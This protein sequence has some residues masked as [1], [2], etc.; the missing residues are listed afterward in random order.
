MLSISIAWGRA[1]MMSELIGK[2]VKGYHIHEV[3]RSDEWGTYYRA[4]QAV[5]ERMV[6]IKHI[7]PRY[8]NDPQFIRNFEVEARLVASLEH[9]HILPLYDFWRDREGAYLVSRYVRGSLAQCL[10]Q[11]SLSLKQVGK[12]IEQVGS[13]LHVAH[14]R[15]IIHHRIM[16]TAI[17]LDE[18]GNAYIGDFEIAHY[19]R[20]S[21]TQQISVDTDAGRFDYISP[22]QIHGKAITPQTDMYCLGIVLY[23]MLTG[24]HPFA[25]TSA[26]LKL[27]NHINESLPIIEDLPDEIRD[28][29]NGILRKATEKYPDKRY[30]TVKQLTL[31]LTQ[32]IGEGDD[33]SNPDARQENNIES[34]FWLENP[35]KGLR[36]FQTIDADDFFGRDAFVDKL[37]SRMQEE[38]IYQRFL[39]V[40]GASGSGK[41]SV[42]KAGLLPRLFDGAV[43]DSEGWFTVEMFPSENPLQELETALASVAVQ[44]LDGIIPHL[45]NS[46]RGL[47]HLAQVILPEVSGEL[48][49][50]I[51]QFDEVFTLVGD[52]SKRARFLDLLWFACTHVSSR[53]RVIIALGSD[54]ARLAAKYPRFEKLLNARYE[55]LSKPSEA[56]LRAII[57]GPVTRVGVTIEDRLVDELVGD[58][59]TESHSLAHLQYLLVEL[60]ERR[61][62]LVIDRDTYQETG[63]FRAFLPRR[64][65][66]IFDSLDEQHQSVAQF[67][68]TH[69]AE[70]AP[71]GTI[72][73]RRVPYEQLKSLSPDPDAT[74]VVLQLFER[75]R[76][77]TFDRDPQTQQPTAELSS[78]SLINNWDRLRGWILQEVE[79]K[80]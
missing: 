6:E 60:F 64:A 16:P 28:V 2:N 1:E 19:T 75:Y 23:E 66:E 76:L 59:Q 42:V 50:F 57:C 13:A 8:T 67:I 74:Q 52:E 40:I 29:L 34:L 79:S 77:I 69:L 78:D 73:K 45:M 58:M 36:S 22:E 20:K 51:D 3:I 49:I 27:Y 61:R 37:I 33:A 17:R 46:P 54:L 41:S 48:L 72:I 12:I 26:K 21:V 24:K 38:H 32:G 15:K 56:E 63:G 43:G 53:V 71:S 65:D 9:P 18:D 31:E 25:T 4:T 5:I 80:S 47:L 14:T 11:E 62:D 68:F 10:L 35:F 39:A 7:S 55:V 44:P 70:L 30:P